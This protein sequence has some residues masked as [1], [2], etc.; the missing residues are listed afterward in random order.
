[1]FRI[2]CPF[3]HIPLSLQEL[4]PV[5]LNEHTCLICP[6]CE[7]VLVTEEQYIGEER[8]EAHVVA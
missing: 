5:Q 6:E 8:Q 7:G 4:E 3:C 2:V 1:M